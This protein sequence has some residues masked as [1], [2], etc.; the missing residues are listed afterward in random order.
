VKRTTI[1]YT[2]GIVD[3]EGSIQ[4]NAKQSNNRSKKRYW[5]LTVQISGTSVGQLEKLRKEWGGIGSCTYFERGAGYT[6]VTNWRMYSKTA[7][8]FLKAVEP[9]MRIKKKQA[10]LA[11]RFSALISPKRD[12]LTPAMSRK[13]QAIA[14]KVRLLNSRPGRPPY[15]ALEAL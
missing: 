10:V 9:Y 12:S 5:E 1:A 15:I 11:I 7:F 13:R 14:T 8:K 2:A 4:I 6:R 3:G